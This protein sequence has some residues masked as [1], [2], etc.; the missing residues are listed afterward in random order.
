MATYL[1]TFF[2]EKSIP[3]ETWDI[4][5]KDG[6]FNIIG[7]GVVVEHLLMPNAEEFFSPEVYKWIEDTMRR[8]DFHNG[9]VN[10]LLH[11]IALMITGAD[12]ETNVYQKVAA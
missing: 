10:H 7:T 9:N 8:I 5:G 11:H 6:E 4:T 12:P 3:C 1:E 2:S